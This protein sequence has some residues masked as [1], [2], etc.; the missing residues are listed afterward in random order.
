MKLSVGERLNLMALIPLQASMTNHRVLQELRKRLILNE[1]ECLN[2][3]IVQKVD[4]EGNIV[5]ISWDISKDD[6]EIAISPEAYELITG[7]FKMLEDQSVPV[8]HSAF[9]LYERLI[10]ECQSQWYEESYG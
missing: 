9:Q 7:H 8:S 5:I 3:Q 1:E 10:S 4:K 2:Y 6:T